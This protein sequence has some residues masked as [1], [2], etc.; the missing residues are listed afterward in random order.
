MSGLTRRQKSPE[1]FKI[2]PACEDVDPNLNHLQ[3]L[4]N[5]LV[6]LPLLNYRLLLLLYN[7]LE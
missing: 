4:L 7:N 6:V 2:V 5:L 3:L 1:F